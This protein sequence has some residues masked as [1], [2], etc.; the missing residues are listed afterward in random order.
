MLDKT[1][2]AASEGTVETFRR[3]AF[4]ASLP[5]RLPSQTFEDFPARRKWFQ[6]PWPTFNSSYLGHFSDHLIPLELTRPTSN[7]DGETTFDR[8]EAPFSI[9][10]EWA[11]RAV[12]E[13]PR[14]R[15]YVAQASLDRLPK[16]LQ[17]DLPTPELVAKTGNGNLYDASIWLGVAPT[18]TPLHRDPNP[19]LYL[20]LAG[21][22]TIRLLEPDAGH[23]AFA[24]VQAALRSKASSK[25]RGEE[26]MKGQERA[27]L[28][29][30]IWSNEAIGDGKETVGYEASLD[31]GE[32]MFI[33]QGWWHSVKSVGV[34]CTGSPTAPQQ[35]PEDDKSGASKRKRKDGSEAPSRTKRNRYI[36]IACARDEKSD[37]TAKCHVSAVATSP[38]SAS[39]LRTAAALA[40]ETPICSEFQA[41]SNTIQSLQDQVQRLYAD[42]GASRNV[43]DDSSAS[44]YPDPSSYPHQPSMI[45]AQTE[46]PYHTTAP[47][48]VPSRVRHRR[49]Q[50]PTS[51]AFNIDV[52]K[53]SLQTMG[54]T[55]PSLIEGQAQDYED[56]ASPR[57]RHASNPLAPSQYVKDPLWSIGK[58]EAIRL[59]RVYDEEI[60]IMYPIL[61]MDQIIEKAG[62]LFTFTEAATKTGLIDRSRPGADSMHGPDID[63]L[64]MI[65]ATA[66]ILEG[67][68][69]SDLGSALFDTVKDSCESK[70][71]ETPDIGGLRLLVIMAQ[72]RFQQGEDFQAYRAIGLAARLSYEVGLHRNNIVHRD[73]ASN[74]ERSWALKLFW[75][76]FVLDRRWSFGTGL[77]FAIQDADIDPSLPETDGSTPYLTAMIACS[78]IASKVWRS[79]MGPVGAGSEIEEETMS[80]LDYQILE[81]QNHIPDS[82]RFYP[83]ADIS[84]TGAPSRAQRRLQ[85]LLYLRANQMRILIYRPVLHSAT[86]IMENRQQAGLVVEVAKDTV[87][88][89][90]RLNQTTDIYRTQQVCFNHF[91]VSALAALF[92][93][94][95]H[96]PLEFNQSV[97]DEFYMAIDLVNGFSAQ[98]YVSM[99]LWETIKGLKEIGPRLGLVSRPGLNEPIDPHSSAAVAMA[100]LAGH[101]VDETT[102]FPVSHGAGTVGQ[103]PMNGQQMSYEL[104]NLFEAAGGYSNGMM[105]SNS[106]GIS[107]GNSY[108]AGRRE[109]SH[110]TNGE[111]PRGEQ[112]HEQYAK[113][114]QALF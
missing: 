67:G 77:P 42:L 114:M 54:L 13:A 15:L 11:E 23:S 1:L 101:R 43:Q 41:M 26:M 87:R 73:F 59:C 72:Y 113:I 89:L 25:F 88:V 38:C 18:Y 71:W 47:A 108:A 36:S 49:F 60:A 70:L 94:V 92:L 52:A 76:I 85:V 62:K 83:T 29:A 33:P 65:V 104:T 55:D 34:G 112:G 91:L 16:P 110:S 98:S 79:I 111:G 30:C 68:G 37:A 19:N 80:Y 58:D 103:S 40:S 75:S 53:S 107:H 86:G 5:A 96:A 57:Q 93:A 8:A 78:R 44:P 46:G 21:R 10:L 106:Q 3:A 32:S 6:A 74:D 99:R 4:S 90:S 97:R 24:S 9:F 51:S 17:D 7:A 84:D 27:L 69:Q 35:H 81:W 102:A 95:S 50:G 105:S 48:T 66:L 28:E 109:G 39:T 63:I 31:A 20:Q 64:K 12:T 14:Q 45:Q 56:S 22:K 61:D 100:G 2:Q 82:L